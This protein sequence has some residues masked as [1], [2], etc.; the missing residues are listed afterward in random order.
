M[1]TQEFTASE[2]YQKVIS[3]INELGAA[4]IRA[5]K[6]EGFLIE[7]IQLTKEEAVST[8]AGDVI[9]TATNFK[10]RL[11][12]SASSFLPTKFVVFNK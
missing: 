5:C 3:F 12:E 2:D 10:V 8:K 7:E 9:E 6:R 11:D 1:T 4:R